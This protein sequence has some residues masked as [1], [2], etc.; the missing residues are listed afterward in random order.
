MQVISDTLRNQTD[1]F[2]TRNGILEYSFLDLRQVETNHNLVEWLE[3]G[4]AGTM[5][6]MHRTADKRADIRSAFPQYA[7]ALICSL[8]YY[9]PETLQNSK[10]NRIS[11]YAQGRDYH[12]VLGKILKNYLKEMSLAETDLDGRFYVDTG[13]ISEKYLA[14][15]TALG[16]I[17]KNTNLIHPK[18]GSFFFLGVVLLNRICEDFLPTPIHC[19]NCVRCI[20]ACPTG[21]LYEPFKLDSRRCLSYIT[22]ESKDTIPEAVRL[23]DDPWLYGCD[24]CQTACPYNR[25]SKLTPVEEFKTRPEY[26]IDHFLSLTEKQ[27]LIEFQGSPI[28][29]IGYIKFLENLVLVTQRIG[30]NKQKLKAKELCEN[31]PELQELIKI[32]V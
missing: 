7:T 1:H 11:S 3:N 31:K 10:I 15:H 25:F 9:N 22:I 30:T 14:S 12:K 21:A 27:F 29:R 13:P 26:T 24:D 32:T 16:W 18:H 19:G 8:S 28:R 2:L 20:V 5:Q 17:G 23:I 4:N 6:W